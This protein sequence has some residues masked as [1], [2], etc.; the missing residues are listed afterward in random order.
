MDIK[1]LIA[2]GDKLLYIDEAKFRQIVELLEQMG[3]HPDIQRTIGVIRP[4]MVELRIHRRP[5]LKRLFCDPFED[6]FETFGKDAPMPLSII[7]R[8]LM[9]SLWP[10][11]EKQIGRERLKGFYG[12]LRDG[13]QQQGLAEAFW[14][15]AAVAV[16]GIASGT[17]AGHFDEA[18]GQ[19]LSPDR[20]RAVADIATILSIAPEIRDLKAALSPKPVSKLH[21][22]HLDGIQDVGAA[23]RGRGPKR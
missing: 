15:E 7:E 20:V 6:L 21:Q 16:A 8:S 18:L 2:L 22:D 13:P 5:T 11:V 17:E 19:R 3:D 4:R 10:L 9:N 14:A 12:A 1:D 23:S